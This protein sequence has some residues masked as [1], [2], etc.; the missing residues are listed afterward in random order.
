MPDATH[1]NHHPV[2]VKGVVFVDRRVLLLRNDR[3]EWELPGGRPEAGETWP[4]ALQREID[5]EANLSVE[6]GPL[7]HEW[8]YEVLPGRFV[9]IVAYGCELAR[10]TAAVVSAEHRELCFWPLDKIDG[11]SLHDGYRAVI[12]TWSSWERGP[13]ARIGA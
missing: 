8:P 5:E 9:W 11:L 3:D 6:V 10:A 4:Q 12:D 7:L 2:S 13:P 1:K